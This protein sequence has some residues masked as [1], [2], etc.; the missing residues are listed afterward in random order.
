M[1]SSVYWLPVI[2]YLT[3]REFL[4]FMTG[5]VAGWFILGILKNLLDAIKWF[6]KR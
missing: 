5:G 4:L 1:S 6:I 3:E 2:G